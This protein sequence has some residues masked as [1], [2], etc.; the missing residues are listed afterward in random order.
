ML[1]MLN[2]FDRF[3]CSE[4]DKDKICKITETNRKVLYEA[5]RYYIPNSMNGVKECESGWVLNDDPIGEESHFGKIFFSNC[6]QEERDKK[7]VAKVIRADK[8]TSVSE[9]LEEMKIQQYVYDHCP[10]ITTPIY[11]VFL[12]KNDDFV[13][14]ITDLI[15]GMTVKR[16]MLINLSDK[17]EENKNKRLLRVKNLLIYCKQLLKYLNHTCQVYH[18]DS[19]LNNFMVTRDSESQTDYIKLIDYGNGEILEGKS[20]LYKEEKYLQSQ[21]K[22]NTSFTMIMQEA[23]HRTGRIE[24]E[25]MIVPILTLATQKVDEYDSTQLPVYG[26]Y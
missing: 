23:K 2:V 25:K 4:E 1:D 16:D 20:Q 26:R 7:Y 14:M 21:A 13:I 18:G 15:E 19:H 12:E 9:I 8:G 22:I 3:D 10:K 5:K 11:Q 24:Y 17:S 6:G